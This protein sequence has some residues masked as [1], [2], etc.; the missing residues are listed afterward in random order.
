MDSLHGLTTISVH[1]NKSRTEWGDSSQCASKGL[2]I[3]LLRLS[4]LSCEALLV[5][6]FKW[7]SQGEQ[8]CHTG[9]RKDGIFLEAMRALL[10]LDL[11]CGGVYFRVKAL[12]SWDIISA[13]SHPFFEPPLSTLTINNLH[14]EHPEMAPTHPSHCLPQPELDN[15]AWIYGDGHWWEYLLTA[16]LVGTLPNDWTWDLEWSHSSRREEAKKQWR[17]WEVVVIPSRLRWHMLLNVQGRVASANVITSLWSGVFLPA[18]GSLNLASVSLSPFLVAKSNLGRP[19][20]HSMVG[21]YFKSTRSRCLVSTPEM[22]G[23]CSNLLHS[24]QIAREANGTRK[25]HQSHF[26]H[27]VLVWPLWLEVGVTTLKSHSCRQGS[28]AKH[29]LHHLGHC[30]AIRHRDRIDKISVKLYC[31]QKGMAYDFMQEHKPMI[32]SHKIVNFFKIKR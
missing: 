15:W 31:H 2:T 4:A 18:M 13:I 27:I 20:C 9:T 24:D 19:F 32:F 1:R 17:H 14:S 22:G 30:A 23:L 11:W 5:F 12:E 10:H 26:N 8:S 21:Q 7:P 6:P 28:L 16:R 29:G 3:S 25:V